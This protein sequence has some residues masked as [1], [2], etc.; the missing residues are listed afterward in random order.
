M[1]PI[2]PIR[3]AAVVLASILL[4]LVLAPAAH[5][6]Y[7]CEEGTVA[8]WFYF[9]LPGDDPVDWL[10]RC[11]FPPALNQQY[12]VTIVVNAVPFRKL[13]FSLPDPPYGFVLAESWNGSVTG[14]RVNGMELDMGTCTDPG[15]V[16]IG[17]LDIFFYDP[18]SVQ[19][20]QWN[21]ASGAEVMDCTGDWRPASAP[22]H[23]VPGGCY[24]CCWQCCYALS[25]YDMY[26]PNGAVDVPTNVVLQ[27]H[28]VGEN[29]GWPYGFACGVMIGTNPNCTDN[30]R[31][32]V[33]CSE[34]FFAPASL[35]PH[36]TYYWRP[37]WISAGNGECTNPDQDEANPKG[38]LY[39]FTTGDGPL[40][41]TPATW[42]H[43]KSLYRE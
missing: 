25:A 17:Y 14:D 33:D 30:P 8:A 18:G 31:F 43:V 20:T 16:E 19:C 27:W 38:P 3:S 5:A 41:T 12:R 42:G 15:A 9:E 21:V 13:R 11:D 6:V 32:G 36:T 37:A 40:V 34:W 35:Q 29:S 39:S 22:P 10:Y 26:P 24:L 2:K 7:S 1:Q 4:L 28:T 23:Y